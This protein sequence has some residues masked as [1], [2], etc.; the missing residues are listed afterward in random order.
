[1][2]APSGL[3]ALVAGASLSLACGGDAGDPASDAAGACDGPEDCP[4]ATSACE[5][6]TC[7]SGA[8]GFDYAPE[9][10]EAPGAE[11]GDCE[12]LVCD[13]EGE[14]VPEPD[15]SALPDDENACTDNLCD[16]GP[17]HPP[18]PAGT[19]CDEDGGNTCD[20]A[21]A[22]VDLSAWAVRVG[23]EGDSIPSAQAAPVFIEHRRFD[24]TLVD[25]LALPTSAAG[26]DVPLTLKGT[27]GVVGAGV[28]EGA[29]TR[30]PG[31]DVVTLGGF[32]AE[33]GQRVA[34][35]SADEVARAVAQIDG[36]GE[37]DTS[38]RVT[39]AFSG[40]DPG[41]IR[42]V[43]SGA[44]STLMWASGPGADGSGGIHHLTLGSS[45]DTTQIAS[46]PASPRWLQIQ[47][48]ELYGS[49]SGRIFSV[50]DGLPTGGAPPV[51]DIPD[52]D[53]SS[54]SGFALLDRRAAVSGPDTLYAAD[55]TAIRRFEIVGGEW[56]ETATFDGGAG[57]GARGLAVRELGAA[58]AL[59]AV[60]TESEAESDEQTPRLIGY[61][62]DFA[63]DDPPLVELAPHAPDT[64]YRGVALPPAE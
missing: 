32:A 5:I 43:V 18:R 22:C 50:G 51:T 56:T 58:V 36:A 52:L 12:I 61:I 28:L 24:G 2:L 27:D 49:A 33:P 46:D 16:D 39:S 62:D 9:G 17:A 42:A 4:S 57:I 38:T 11:P 19:P 3:T 30:S 25:T 37:I 31:Q 47:G 26:A 34:D 64:L 44:D 14:A 21:G 40:G 59:F 13:A 60:T 15:E 23:E 35:T 10:T 63:T 6:P 8:C 48:G 54:P 41:G 20:G 45:G 55:F 1:M 53:L 7:E 29:L